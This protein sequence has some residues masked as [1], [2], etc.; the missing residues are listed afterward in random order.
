MLLYCIYIYIYICFRAGERTNFTG[1]TRAELL[2]ICVRLIEQNRNQLD[3]SVLN[4]PLVYIDKNT[5]N[6]KQVKKELQ[7]Q[8]AR[9][10]GSPERK[11]AVQAL[12]KLVFDLILTADTEEKSGN[13]KQKVSGAAVPVE[14]VRS[15]A[16]T[17][18]QTSSKSEPRAQEDH[19]HTDQGMVKR[20]VTSIGAVTVSICFGI[21]ILVGYAFKTHF[22][23]S[24]SSS[25]LR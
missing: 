7:L 19:N 15:R 13:S 24:S 17:S 8:L 3:A 22:S 9:D 4:K 10:T 21:G 16:Q 14:S 18:S 5:P 20:N 25:S 6:R 2:S 11:A 23:N 12:N 1:I